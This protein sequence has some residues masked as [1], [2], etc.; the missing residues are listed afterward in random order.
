LEKDVEKQVEKGKSQFEGPEIS[1][2]TL[3]VIG[4]GAIGVL[5]ANMGIKLGMRV[6][7]YDPYISVQKAI[8]LSWDVSYSSSLNELLRESDYISLHIP[9]M[10]DTKYFMDKNKLSKMKSGSKLINMSRGGLVDDDAVVE[11]IEGGIIDRYVTDFPTDKLVKQN[12]VICI[13]HLGASTPESEENCAR[14]A[15]EQLMDYLENGNISNSVNFPDC[16]MDHIP[17]TNRIVILN[18]NIPSMISSLSAV[19]AKHQI[20]IVS[21]V[22]KSKGDYACNIIDIEPNKGNGAKLE[23]LK[24]INGIINVRQ[25]Y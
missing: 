8:G 21:M 17:N 15:V 11:A 9:L 5:V 14:M 18:R 25:V 7:G 22:N 4:L 12:G 6:I 13:P 16:Y 20:N 24:K 2:K 1:G 10:D 19:F 23:E 3:G